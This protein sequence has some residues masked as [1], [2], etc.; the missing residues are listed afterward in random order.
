MQY[1]IG[2]DGGG[3]K[4][5]AVAYD[6]EG[7]VLGEGRSGFSNVMV[8]FH[9]ATKHILAAIK[10]AQQHLENEDCKYI[11]LGIAGSEGIE[12]K[13]ELI[14]IL[15]DEFQSEISVVNDSIIAHA[16]TLKG[17]DGI[18][19]ISGTGAIAVGIK[20]D[21]CVFSG[22]WGH[23]LGDEGSGYWIV[24]EAFRQIIVET[25]ESLPLCKL[26]DAILY[27]MGYTD[28]QDIKLYAYSR[29]KAEIAKLSRVV[30][31]LA[32]A[33]D[34]IASRILYDA[35]Q[36]LGR[37]TWNCCKKLGLNDEVVIG[38]S[39]SIFEHIPQVMDSYKQYLSEKI[40]VPITLVQN[41]VPATKGAYYLAT[42]TV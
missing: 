2:V 8:D 15:A 9:E 30:T 38:L 24:M 27:E 41:E 26:S 34:E 31:R 10:Q 12:N 33:G 6:L 39:G 19:A 3:T 14:Q 4:T 42:K 32:D 22:G 36:Q 17:K 29:P 13:D 1:V 23:L 11:Y 21:K 40:Q 37:M 7:N 28:P 5:V 35:G 25:D 18:L 16:A 20:G